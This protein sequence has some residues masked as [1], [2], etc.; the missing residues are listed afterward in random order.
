M[1]AS[2]SAGLAALSDYGIPVESNR[3]VCHNTEE[4]AAY[5]QEMLEQRDQWHCEADGIVIKVDDLA[6]QRTLGNTGHEPR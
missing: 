4:V 6:Q 2:Q 5:Y 1:L 3:R